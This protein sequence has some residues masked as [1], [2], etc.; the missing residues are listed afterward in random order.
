M[1]LLINETFNIQ[2][3]MECG[4]AFRY[5][6]LDQANYE[7]IAFGKRLRVSQDGNEVA[8]TCTE[9]AFENL[10]EAYFD[11][12]VDYQ[13]L[14][15]DLVAME[16][17][18]EKYI[19]KKPGI[20]I[21]KQEP[22]EMMITFILSQNKSMPQIMKLVN[23]VAENYGTKLEDQWG[24]YHV[25]PRPEQLSLVSEEA[26]RAL[27]VGFRAPY[28]VDAISKVMDGRVDLEQIEVLPTDEA[29]T[30]LLQVK[31]IGRK[32]ADC[33]LL[34]AYH[35]MDVF[36]LDVW[37]KRAIT[38]LYFAGDKVSDQVMLKKAEETFGQLSGI[39]QQYIFYGTVEGME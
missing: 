13:K 4:Q 2:D 5:V 36:P 29:R 28:L 37:M 25:F 26:F 19:D 11:L 10:W 17:R 6:K 7:I 21:L 14:Q 12:K 39:A 32:V 35:R 8:F 18:L 22:F 15:K 27:K 33:I 24:T 31:G 9:V 1:K 34:F 38:S 23:R 30:M 20:R 16:P 3:I